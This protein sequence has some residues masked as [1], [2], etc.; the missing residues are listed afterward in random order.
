MPNHIQP[1]D[2]T[3]VHR[4][5]SGQVV[6]DLSSAVKE[7]LENSVDAHAKSVEIRFK[8]YGIDSIEVVD[9]GDG[10]SKNDF[11]AIGKIY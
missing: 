10:I 4:I 9:D 7:L 11:E 8:N 3:S 6:I 2:N 5:T 1:I